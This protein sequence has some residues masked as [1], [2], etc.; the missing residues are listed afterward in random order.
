MFAA[1][2]DANSKV[3]DA[4]KKTAWQ[5]VNRDIASKYLPAIPLWYAPPSLV[6][7]K[8]V[9]GLVPSPL[10]DERFNTVSVTK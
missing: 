7:T 3:D 5:Q 10:T 9:S 4:A 6:A 1:I 2:A 8:K